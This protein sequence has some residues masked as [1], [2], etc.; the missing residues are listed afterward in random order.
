M[1]NTRFI[2]NQTIE[3]INKY[4]D[5]ICADPVFLCSN[6]EY[7]GTKT[8]IYSGIDNVKQICND[9]T[10]AN[11]CENDIQ[12]CVVLAENL[13]ESSQKYIATSFE[14]IIIPIPKVIDNDGNNIFIRLPELKPSKKANSQEICSVCACMNRFAISPGTGKNA[15]ASTSPGQNECIY[16]DKFEYYYYPTYIKEVN[17]KIKNPP[18]I[19]LNSYRI[20]DSNIIELKS[21]NDLQANNLYNILLSAGIS[22]SLVKQ[23]ITNILY[24]GNNDVLNQLNL[25]IKSV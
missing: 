2:Q 21:E 22:N 10:K 24:K 23:F 7:C 19:I 5:D 20:L 17:S 3:Q 13:F 18:A 15:D 4:I 14:N 16:P 6:I 12:Q 25:S 1:E 9:I 8:S 11:Q